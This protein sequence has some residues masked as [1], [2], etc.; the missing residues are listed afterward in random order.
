MGGLDLS[1]MMTNEL[2][3]ARIVEEDLNFRNELYETTLQLSQQVD[4]FMGLFE[5][6]LVERNLWLK[7]EQVR[8]ALSEQC[9][10]SVQTEAISG[11]WNNA[12]ID[13][14]DMPPK[15]PL[16]T[17]G[18]VENLFIE[19]KETEGDL[20][21]DSCLQRIKPASEKAWGSPFQ[22]NSCGPYVSRY[23]N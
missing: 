17:K 1:K 14:K 12:F 5:T 4:S 7:K 23:E 11:P 8:N 13:K 6:F 20:F 10:K 22:S 2:E 18:V 15:E 3:F 16:L 21:L 9:C 19:Q